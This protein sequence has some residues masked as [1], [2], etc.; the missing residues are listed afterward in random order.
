MEKGIKRGERGKVVVAVVVVSVIV[1]MGSRNSN[2]NSNDQR[3][4]NN[5]HYR[6]PLINERGAS[7]GPVWCGVGRGGE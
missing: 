6:I 7:N 4:I 1:M 5:T 2:S 3:I